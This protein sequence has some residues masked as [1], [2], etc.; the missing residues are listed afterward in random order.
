VS[1]R[2]PSSG[3]TGSSAS[4]TSAA[5]W[6]TGTP[7]PGGG[8]GGAGG[9]ATLETESITYRHPVTGRDDLGAP[10]PADR[11]G[12]P[13]TEPD[14]TRGIRDVSF[15][16]PAGRTVAVVG[17]TGSGKTTLAT[18]LVRLFDPDT[19]TLRLDGV[20][21]P[22]LDRDDLAEQVAIV[23][24]EPFV[25][26]D[27]VRGNVTL[28]RDIPD[29]QVLEALRLAG[30]DGF[31]ASLPDGLDT[32]VGERGST[33]SGGQRQ[34]IALARALVRRPRLLVLD[35]A[36][37]AVDAAVEAEILANLR[38]AAM[39]STVVIIAYRTGSISLADEV[40][41]VRDGTIAAR[42][43]HEDLLERVPAYAHLVTA[44]EEA[45]AEGYGDA[46]RAREASA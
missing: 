25:F 39:P 14:G 44:Y 21:L 34:R 42:G 26:D 6:S 2:A 13:A 15:D 12:G 33:L 10:G 29:E 36:T 17:P 30:A 41:F 24:Q 4:S 20:N 35:D 32:E 8:A 5:R 9:G 28:G 18:L 22:D 37:S 38:D 27:T 16:V 23:F 19:G 3:W 31:V 46:P 45:R 1:C 7:G 11:S 40:V 43:P